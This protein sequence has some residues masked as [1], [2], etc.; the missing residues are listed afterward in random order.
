[1]LLSDQP[2]HEWVKNHCRLRVCLKVTLWLKHDGRLLLF[3]LKFVGQTSVNPSV[4]VL[5][6]CTVINA[7]KV[8]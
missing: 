3:T 4:V 8:L 7:F 2:R 5:V 1:M 6:H